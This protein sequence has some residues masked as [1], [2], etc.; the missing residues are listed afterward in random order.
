MP[1]SGSSVGKRRGLWQACPEPL[2]PWSSADQSF[3]GQVVP[4]STWDCTGPVCA[5]APRGPVL[6]V[7]PSVPMCALVPG[8]PLVRPVLP[9][10][11]SGPPGSSE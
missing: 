10:S 4:R 3:F 6:Y 1:S 2:F 5:R 9:R 11:G 8:G 7:E